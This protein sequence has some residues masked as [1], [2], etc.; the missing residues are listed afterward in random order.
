MTWGLPSWTRLALSP[1]EFWSRSCSTARS[2][3]LRQLL[4]LLLPARAYGYRQE[5]LHEDA[6]QNLID[7]SH[8][9]NYQT[10]YDNHEEYDW[11]YSPWQTHSW[12]I[13]PIKVMLGRN[14]SFILFDSDC[15]HIY[16]IKLI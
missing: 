8:L 4:R 15:V 6:M 5:D 16:I 2:A 14:L 10:T 9:I 11:P 7:G 1:S 3:R 13:L 12:Y